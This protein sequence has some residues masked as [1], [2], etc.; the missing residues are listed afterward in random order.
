MYNHPHESLFTLRPPWSPNSIFRL[1]SVSLLGIQCLS[2]GLVSFAPMMLKHLFSKLSE[3]V[4]GHFWH[5]SLITSN[6]SL[7]RHIDS[8]QAYGNEAEVAEAIRASGV[9]R[10]DVFVSTCWNYLPTGIRAYLVLLQPLNVFQEPTDM[11]QLLEVSTSR[12][13]GWSLV[14]STES[15]DHQL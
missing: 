7:N 4:I 5:H 14:S 8:A 2:L 1:L 10:E 6:S 13:R 12:W 9:P 15:T 3:R 11:N